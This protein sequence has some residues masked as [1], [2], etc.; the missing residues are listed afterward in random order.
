ML[1]DRG[2]TLIEL[3]ITVA[4]VAILAAVALPSYSAYVLRA[5]ITDAVKG[6]SEMRLKMEQYFQDNRKWAGGNPPP[7]DPAGGAPL[8]KNTSNFTFACTT[9]TAT[10]YTVTATGIG[11]MTGFVYTIDQ[12]NV[13]ATTSAP[14]GWPAPC[15][16]RWLTKKSDTCS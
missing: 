12:A 6:L 13:Q 11:S 1:A 16:A 15:G 8:P 4:I 7:C 2:F 9:L 3:M 5:N 10:A 14:V